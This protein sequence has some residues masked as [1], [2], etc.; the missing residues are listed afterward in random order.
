MHE[1]QFGRIENMSVRAD[2]P[3]ITSHM[4]VVRVA[5][6]GGCRDAAK[7]TGT[8]EFELKRLIFCGTGSCTQLALMCW[9]TDEEEQRYLR[10]ERLFHNSVS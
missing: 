9:L 8:D 1:H 4:K 5:R 6:L 3:A 2:E 7:V 10:G